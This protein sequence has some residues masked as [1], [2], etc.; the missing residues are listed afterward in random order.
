MLG[1]RSPC[2][3]V[4]MV[5]GF[6]ISEDGGD[7]GVGVFKQFF[8]MCAGFGCENIREQSGLLCPLGRIVLIAVALCIQIQD[9]EH[10]I[11]KFWLQTSDRHETAVLRLVASVKGA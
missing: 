8:P 6:L 3:I 2:K 11:E 4:G 10:F 5:R 1:M 9:M 7:A